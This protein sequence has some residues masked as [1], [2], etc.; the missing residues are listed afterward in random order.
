MITANW[1][2]S[3]NRCLTYMCNPLGRYLNF[4]WRPPIVELFEVLREVNRG[5]SKSYWIDPLHKVPEMFPMESHLD[6][7]AN[8]LAGRLQTVTHPFNNQTHGA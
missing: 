6:Y 4:I 5:I 3:A 7:T 2:H 8:N 1:L